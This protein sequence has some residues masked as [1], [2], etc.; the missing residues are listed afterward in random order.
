[1]DHLVSV[2]GSGEGPLSTVGEADLEMR[3][4]CVAFLKNS[5][6]C[7]VGPSRAERGIAG[8][9][10]IPL[11]GKMPVLLRVTAADEVVYL[12]RLLWRPRDFITELAEQRIR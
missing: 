11:T 4:L 10:Y 2:K 12:C 1:M 9:S 7:I 8:H 3:M 5:A 6:S